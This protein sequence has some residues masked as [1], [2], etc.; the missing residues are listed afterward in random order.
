MDEKYT[1]PEDFDPWMAADAL[2]GVTEAMYWFMTEGPGTGQ[3]WTRGTHAS[4]V[5]LSWIARRLAHQL[6]AYMTMLSEAGIELPNVNKPDSEG[7]GETAGAYGL[8]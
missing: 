6:H 3:T 5:G 1:L 2:K 8:N 7:I 4:L